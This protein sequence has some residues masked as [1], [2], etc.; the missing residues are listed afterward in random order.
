FT[1]TGLEPAI[2]NTAGDKVVNDPTA[3]AATITIS[4]SG[5][6]VTVS[7]PEWPESFQFTNPGNVTVNAGAGDDA[8]TIQS[9]DTY[10]NTLTVNG[11]AGDDSMTLAAISA[12]ATYVINGGVEDDS[13][14][15]T[16]DQ[17]FSLNDDELTVGAKTIGIS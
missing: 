17:D 6:G 5:G 14:T 13:I 12:S 8:I 1:F 3:G 11:D 15:V 16:A 7:A 4:G 9:L 2:D 10:A